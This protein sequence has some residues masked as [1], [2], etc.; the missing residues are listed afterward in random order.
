MARGE[1]GL[2]SNKKEL[3]EYIR[4]FDIILFSMF[5]VFG[6]VGI[7]TLLFVGIPGIMFI[8]PAVL[9]FSYWYSAYRAASTCVD[10]IEKAGSL[11]FQAARFSVL[12]NQSSDFD[13]ARMTSRRIKRLAISI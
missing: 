10:S 11:D 12:C 7:A 8:I 2:V 4:T 1:K 9:S 5:I 6:L 3:I 13:L